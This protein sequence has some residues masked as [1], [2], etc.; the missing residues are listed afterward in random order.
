[1]LVKTIKI[2]RDLHPSTGRRYN[3]SVIFAY[4]PSEIV[5]VE[6]VSHDYHGEY[7]AACRVTFKNGETVVLA[8]SV[9]DVI[10]ATMEKGE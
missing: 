2:N 3:N 1:M 8:C 7:A 4:D 10:N 6:N 5:T 9:Q